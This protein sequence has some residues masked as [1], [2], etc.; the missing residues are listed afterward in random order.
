[1]SGLRF[2][3]CDGK[4]TNVGPRVWG[5]APMTAAAVGARMVSGDVDG[6]GCNDIAVVEAL[7]GPGARI[8]RLLSNGSALAEPASGDWSVSSDYDLSL[9]AGRVA[10]SDID[11]DGRDDVIATYDYGP[12]FRCHVW[13]SGWSYSGPAGWYDSD[14]FGLGLVNGRLVTGVW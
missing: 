13:L 1:M 3:V 11:R 8:R 10:A 9:V 12:D 5:T 14:N 7:P 6:N 4:A 2:D